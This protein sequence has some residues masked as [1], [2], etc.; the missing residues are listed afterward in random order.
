MSTGDA[1]CLTHRKAC[2]RPNV[3]AFNEAERAR[4]QDFCGALL[5]ALIRLPPAAGAEPKAIESKREL[6]GGSVRINSRRPVR[7]GAEPALS[8]S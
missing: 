7:C 8:A 3:E 4:F 5:Q 6:K 2:G 1:L